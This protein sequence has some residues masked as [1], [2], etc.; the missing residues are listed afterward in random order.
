M[1]R[2]YLEMSAKGAVMGGGLGAFVGTAASPTVAW[3]VAR[4]DCN[5]DKTLPGKFAIGVI[6]A[7]GAG[8]ALTVGGALLGA[9]PVT[10][11]AALFYDFA[12]KK[13]TTH[14]KNKSEK[15]QPSLKPR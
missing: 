5:L 10:C 12:H 1:F 11:P 7:G 8:L 6:A 15:S 9:A 2:K 3:H 13:Y 14:Q 4:L